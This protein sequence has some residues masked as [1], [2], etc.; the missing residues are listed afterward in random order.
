[1]LIKEKAKEF[2]TMAHNGQVR[3]AE[4]EKPYIVHPVAVAEILESYGYDDNVVAAGYLHDVVEDTIY[5]IDDIINQFGD[6][7]AN[8]VYSAS[9]PDK[10]LSW[11]ER[12]EHTINEIKNKQLR[13]KLVVC[14]DKI[15]NIEDLIRILKLKGFEIYKSFK[16]DYNNQIWYFENVYKSLIFNE[17]EEDPIFRRLKEDIFIFKEEIK[18]QLKNKTKDIQCQN[19]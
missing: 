17:N 16:S 15:N 14:A 4:P 13:N 1:M 5:T 18:H 2:A 19:I 6:D 3:K 11:E 10:T 8:L 7:I 9:E 12:K